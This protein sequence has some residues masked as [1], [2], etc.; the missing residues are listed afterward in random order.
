MRITQVHDQLASIGEKTEYAK[1]MNV[2]LNSLLKSREPF[3]KGVCAREHLLYWQ[4]LLN[5]CIQEETLE[6]SKRNK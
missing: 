6:E 4:R 3:F 1:L 5:D 2:A